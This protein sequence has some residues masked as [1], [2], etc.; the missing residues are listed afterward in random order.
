MSF[1]KKLKQEII[2][3]I[4]YEVDDC[5]KCP[6]FLSNKC[7]AEEEEAEAKATKDAFNAGGG[8][9]NGIMGNS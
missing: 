3:K 1:F 9:F 2:Y 8:R 7:K 5:D 6:A 4:C